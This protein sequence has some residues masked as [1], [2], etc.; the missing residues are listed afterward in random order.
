M[1]WLIVIGGVF[2]W[3]DVLP[4][5][6]SETCEL[7]ELFKSIWDLSSSFI[8]NTILTITGMNEDEDNKLGLELR[9]SS[10]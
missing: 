6:K 9:M 7:A 3:C 10:D 2:L 1:I 4:E 8:A 5:V